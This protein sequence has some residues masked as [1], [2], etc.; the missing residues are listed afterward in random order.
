MFSHRSGLSQPHNE[1]HNKKKQCLNG[2]GA[3]YYVGL[4]LHRHILH[5]LLARVRKGREIWRTIDISALTGQLFGDRTKYNGLKLYETFV[6]IRC[7]FVKKTQLLY[8]CVSLWVFQL[9]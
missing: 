1:I 4:T 5:V 6:D 9:N 3:Q 8:Q 7:E 2:S